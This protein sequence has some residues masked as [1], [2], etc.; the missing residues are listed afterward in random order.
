MRHSVCIC[1]K[2]VA[3]ISFLSAFIVV[4]S[5]NF[6]SM[7]RSFSTLLRERER[8]RL[9]KASMRSAQVAHATM[10]SMQYSR[11]CSIQPAMQGYPQLFAALSA[12]DWTA[13]AAKS[14]P[15]L[16]EL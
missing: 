14:A 8:N 12:L 5:V 16:G 15:P 11:T 3:L 7:A 6:Y 9:H 4:R 2:R 1:A 13:A 10:A